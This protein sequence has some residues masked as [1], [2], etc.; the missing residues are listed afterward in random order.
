MADSAAIYALVSGLG[1]AIIG[2]ATTVYAS[3]RQFRREMAERRAERGRVQSGEEI[4][5]L[6][7]LRFAGRAWLEVVVRAAQNLEAGLAVDL[8]K[9]D[10]D[11]KE[12]G[13]MAAREGYQVRWPNADADLLAG[14]I[15]DSL[16]EVS[17]QIRQSIVAVSLG[18]S[19]DVSRIEGQLSSIRQKRTELNAKI[20]QRI[21]ELTLDTGNVRRAGETGGYTRGPQS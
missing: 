14:W 9:Y 15:Y 3:A 2:S 10:E 19:I 20:I 7:A 4:I 13:G 16:A 8:D 12:A 21:E 6:T 18:N 5:R 17:T 11:V 1:G